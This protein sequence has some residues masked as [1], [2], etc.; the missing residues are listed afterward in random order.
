[1]TQGLVTVARQRVC[2]MGC[3]HAMLLSAADG[4]CSRQLFEARYIDRYTSAVFLHLNLYHP[5]LH[6]IGLL[7]L[8]WEQRPGFRAQASVEVLAVRLQHLYASEGGP[9]ALVLEALVLLL[10][11]VSAINQLLQVRGRLP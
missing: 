11:V 8:A 1:M 10:V 4:S 7:Q 5:T 2:W 9:G 6:R 3:G